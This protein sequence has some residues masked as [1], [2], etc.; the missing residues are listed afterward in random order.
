MG[1]ENVV[2]LR[3]AVAKAPMIIKNDLGEPIYA[4]VFK[5]SEEI[6]VT[7]ATTSGL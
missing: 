5:T 1:R 7:R 4:Q 2:I 6:L 3:G